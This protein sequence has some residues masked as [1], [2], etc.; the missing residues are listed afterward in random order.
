ML[1]KINL[2][3]AWFLMVQIFFRN[4]LTIV[5][6]W[7]LYTLGMPAPL[8]EQFGWLAGGLMLV[9]V[10][11]V[12]RNFLGELPPGVGKRDGKGYRF[13]HR[14]LFANSLLAFG[15]YILPMLVN[16]IH[17]ENLQVLVSMFV[18]DF[19]YMALAAF[20]VGV[21]LIYQSAQTSVINPK[22]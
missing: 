12:M 5:G 1:A 15:V 18:I 6:T 2:F 21:S 7:L 11:L 17:T 14:V 8:H 10:L 22:L 19:M 13:G 4:M 9:S 16:I 20:G 3:V